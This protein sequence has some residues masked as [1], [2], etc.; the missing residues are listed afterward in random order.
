LWCIVE[1]ANQSCESNSTSAQYLP[2]KLKLDEEK[3]K[4]MGLAQP[5]YFCSAEFAEA[6]KLWTSKRLLRLLRCGHQ[7]LT[8]ALLDKSVMD[9]I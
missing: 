9:M 8:P 7:S 5:K 2:C 6:V 4:H 3:S 1:T